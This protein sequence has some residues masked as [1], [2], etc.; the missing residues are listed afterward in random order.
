[1]SHTRLQAKADLYAAYVA[2]EAWQERHLFLPAL[3]FLTTT[4]TRASRFLGA[5][6]RALSYSPRQQGRRAF[7]A[8][9][10]GIAWTPG[11]LL[12]DACLA[13]LDRNTGLTLLDVLKAARAPYEQALARHHE[14]E[15]ADEALRRALRENPQA[16][17]KLLADYTHALSAYVQALGPVGKQAVELLR[18]STDE[19]SPDE[20]AHCA[21][22]HATSMRRYP[23]HERTNCPRPAGACAPR[24]RYWS[25][26]AAPHNP[27][28]SRRSPAATAPVRPCAAQAACSA[29]RRSR[30]CTRRS[31]PRSYLGVDVSSGPTVDA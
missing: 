15:E 4:D 19:P 8:G 14:R 3:L 1:M 16:M 7:V 5:L 29:K 23:N 18:A 13:D 21:Q 12:G 2:S 27:N 17:R 20:R 9:A 10:A 6:A 26:T 25:S 31:C 28:R 24:S 11:R 30:D 22:S